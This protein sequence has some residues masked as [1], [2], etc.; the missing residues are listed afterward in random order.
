M[1]F[2]LALILQAVIGREVWQNMKASDIEALAIYPE[3]RF[4]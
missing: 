1:L 4:V 2:C 3:Q